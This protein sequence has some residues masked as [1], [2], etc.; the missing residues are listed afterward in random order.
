MRRRRTHD[1]RAKYHP[2]PGM[3][4]RDEF[5]GEVNP[6]KGT[7]QG[8]AGE[9]IGQRT[10]QQVVFRDCVIAFKGSAYRGSSDARIDEPSCSISLLR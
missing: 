4:V 7:G 6:G 3:A 9:V 1:S 10:R 8:K 5:A 2:E